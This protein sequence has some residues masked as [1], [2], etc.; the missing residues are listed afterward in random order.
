MTQGPSSIHQYAFYFDSS[1]CSGCKS[2]QVAC[3]DKNG[4]RAGL[5]WRRVYEVTGGGW[6]RRGEAWLSTV[7]SYNVSLACNHCQRP[8]C[9]EV[10]PARA[11]TKRQDG[12]VLLDSSKCVGCQYCRW[13]CPYGAPQYDEEA[14]YMTKCDFCLDNLQAGLAP[15]CVAACPLR[16]LDFG[17]REELEARYGPLEELYPLPERGLTDPALVV[18]PHQEAGRA[19]GDSAEVHLENERD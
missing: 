3:K 19:G 15:A 9:V 14:G 16:A 2:C 8:I 7:F 13:A 18:R 4:L 5:L 6:E 11:I 12:I 10:C 1:S 17:D